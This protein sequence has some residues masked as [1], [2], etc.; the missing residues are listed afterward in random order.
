[1]SVGWLNGMVGGRLVALEYA[2]FGSDGRPSLAMDRS[3][4]VTSL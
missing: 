4:L 3:R 1:M 2:F